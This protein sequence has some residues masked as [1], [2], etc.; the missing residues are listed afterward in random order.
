MHYVPILD[1]YGDTVDMVPYCSDECA[2]TNPHYAGWYG[3]SETEY[4]TYCQSC[5]VILGGVGDGPHCDPDH[6]WPVVVNLSGIP[7]DEY[8]EHGTLIRAG[9]DRLEHYREEEE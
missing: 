8:C 1:D 7:E 4:T 6:V 3:A 9:V 2:Q 5:G